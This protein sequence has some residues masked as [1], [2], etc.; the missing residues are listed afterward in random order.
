MV[1]KDRDDNQGET[2]HISAVVGHF[3]ADTAS[4]ARTELGE[5]RELDSFVPNFLFTIAA[6]RSSSLSAVVASS[7][8]RASWAGIA[9]TAD[10]VTP[11]QVVL[12]EAGG[13]SPPGA[14]PCPSLHWLHLGQTADLG[15][16]GLSALAQQIRG[17]GSADTTPDGLIWCVW[18]NELGSLQVAYS[19]GQLV[20]ILRPLQVKVLIF[21]AESREQGPGDSQASPADDTTQP[22]SGKM[23][24][25]DP[26]ALTTDLV[27][28]IGAD[29]PLEVLTVDQTSA[30][31]DPRSGSTTPVGPP[32]EE[33]CSRLAGSLKLGA[34][35]QRR[36]SGLEPGSKDGK[37]SVP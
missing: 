34:L 29:C 10:V 27:A 33:F 22:S 2:H 1:V 17:S 11:L 6:A 25:P 21:P 13:K 36:I 18:E 28:A 35:A 14:G 5:S 23:V 15:I 31:A 32:S 8:A 30:P 37:L 16:G 7:L 20:R 26:L 4:R 12:T 9:A 24:I 19:L 3:L